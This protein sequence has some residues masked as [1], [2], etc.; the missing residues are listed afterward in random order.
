M[1]IEQIVEIQRI[2]A[3][4]DEERDELARKAESRKD[5]GVRSRGR[6]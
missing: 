6:V 5:K 3:E 1:T 2:Q 4:I